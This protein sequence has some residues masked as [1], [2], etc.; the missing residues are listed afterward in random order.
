MTIDFDD[1]FIEPDSEYAKNIR[2]N[3]SIEDDSGIFIGNCY[4]TNEMIDE[5]QKKKEDKK[6]NTSSQSAG[7]DPFLDF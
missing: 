2:N 1:G 3:L 4:Y 7:Y 5:A 6:K